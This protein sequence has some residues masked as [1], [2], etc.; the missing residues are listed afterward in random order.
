MWPIPSSSRKGRVCA[1]KTLF[2]ILSERLLWF[3]HMPAA[4]TAAG[5]VASISSSSRE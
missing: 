3:V 1:G 5:D 4:L 2:E